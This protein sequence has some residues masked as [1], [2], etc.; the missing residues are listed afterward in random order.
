MKPTNKTAYW[1]KKLI[2]MNMGSEYK[3]SHKLEDYRK[4][5]QSNIHLVWRPNVDI[6]LI[7]HRSNGMIMIVLAIS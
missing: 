6:K 7:E 1:F 2:I 5:L 4:R 3:N